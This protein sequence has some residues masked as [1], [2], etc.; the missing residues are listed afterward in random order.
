MAEREGGR[1]GGGSEPYP[2]TRPVKMEG[3][4]EEGQPKGPSTPPLVSPQEVW[5][6]GS[7]LTDGEDQRRERENGRRET[8]KEPSS[9]DIMGIIKCRNMK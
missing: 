5:A 4:R 6:A 1:G 7:G 2:D 3:G 8:W 9:L